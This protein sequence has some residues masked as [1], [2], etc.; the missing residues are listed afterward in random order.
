MT[1][2][3]L[4]GLKL[5]YITGSAHAQCLHNNQG[6]HG[7][8]ICKRGA[9]SKCERTTNKGDVMVTIKIVGMLM[10]TWHSITSVMT[11]GI[12]HYHK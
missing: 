4:V 8:G 9:D 7:S 5:Q 6:Q 2:H 12:K 10:H 11:N 3:I 1:I